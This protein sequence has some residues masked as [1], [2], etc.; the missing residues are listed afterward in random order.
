LTKFRFLPANKIKP[1]VS[2]FLSFCQV[3][4][5]VS[6]FMRIWLSQFSRLSSYTGVSFRMLHG[7]YHHATSYR[8]VSQQ[9]KKTK[10]I[11]KFEHI[12]FSF[13]VTSLGMLI[14]NGI[15]LKVNCQQ[16]IVI[17]E[18]FIQLFIRLVHIKFIIFSPKYHITI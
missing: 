16:L 10:W 11:S 8:N 12:C 13:I 7:Y 2:V 4:F 17:M 3:L 15:M 18:L 6:L 9:T 5:N 14:P 1:Y